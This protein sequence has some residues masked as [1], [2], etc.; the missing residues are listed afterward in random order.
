MLSGFDLNLLSLFKDTHLHYIVSVQ[1][2]DER[3]I[4]EPDED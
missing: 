2:E 1:L 3:W 4:Y